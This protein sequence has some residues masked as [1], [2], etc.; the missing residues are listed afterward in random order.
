MKYTV[1][2]RSLVI[3]GGVVILSKQQASDRSHNLKPLG[4]DNYE[5]VNPIELK[6]GEVFGYKGDLPKSMVEAIEKPGKADAEAEAKAKADAEAEAKAKADAEA[7]AKAKADAEAEAK[8]KA[9]GN[10]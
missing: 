7:E 4:K 2:A 10:K 3:G 1:T 6:A 8:A 5:V 9:E